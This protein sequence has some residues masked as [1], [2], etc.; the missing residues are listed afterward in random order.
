MTPASASGTLPRHYPLTQSV[1]D[2]EGWL[3]IDKAACSDSDGVVVFI[4]FSVPFSHIAHDFE[5]SKG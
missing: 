2:W 5:A 1:V 3:V 4:S